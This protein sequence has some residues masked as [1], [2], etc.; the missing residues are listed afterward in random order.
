MNI[1][2]L[3]VAA[4]LALSV[5]ALAAEMP[6]FNLAIKDHKFSPSEITVPAGQKVKLIISNQD[7]TPEEFE[8]HALKVEKVI[9]GNSKATVMIGPLKPGAYNFVGE[10]H[11]NTAKGKV[12]AK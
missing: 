8:S 9:P 12:V 6:E 3:V 2:T 11:E 10:F 7:K 5:P 4:A 1:R